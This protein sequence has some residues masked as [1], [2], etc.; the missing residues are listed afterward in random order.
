[1]LERGDVVKLNSGGAE[2][3]VDWVQELEA[4]D[5]IHCKWFD[6]GDNLQ[7]GRFRVEMVKYIRDC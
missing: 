6:S 3:T 4:G 7:S 1:M 5:V 2:M